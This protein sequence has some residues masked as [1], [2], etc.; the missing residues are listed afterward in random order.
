MRVV[1]ASWRR[2]QQER[3]PS[4][5]RQHNRCSHEL[6]SV[7]KPPSIDSFAYEISDDPFNKTEPF[8]YLLALSGRAAWRVSEKNENLQQVGQSILDE[9][10]RSNKQLKRLYQ[11]IIDRHS[12]LS[13]RRDR[14]R[15]RILKNHTYKQS[16]QAQDNSV[17]PMLYGPDE[18][19]SYLKQRLTPNYSITKRVLDEAKSLTTHED[20]APKNII[21]FG[22]GVGSA[23]A[24]AMDVWKD[25]VEWVHG[26]DSSKSMREASTTLLTRYSASFE[27]QSYFRVTTSG[28]LAAE[29]SPPAFDL[30]LFTYTALELTH[31]E[32]V[33]SAAALLW[34]KLRPNG[35]F[36]MIEPGTPDGF[37]SIRTVRN[38]LID[39]CSPEYNDGCEVLAPCSHKGSCPLE[40]FQIQLD[41][42][43]IKGPTQF[44]QGE[45]DD[46]DIEE[47]E[48][49]GSDDEDENDDDI[50]E[51]K[52]QKALDSIKSGRKR[53]KGRDKRIETLIVNSKAGDANTNVGGRDD[54]DDDG[55]GGV[56]GRELDDGLRKGYCSFVQAMPDNSKLRKGEKFSYI[57]LRKTAPDSQGIHKSHAFS[58]DDVTSLLEQSLNPDLS[59][60]GQQN[61]FGRAIDLH[62]RYYGSDEDDLGLELVRGSNLSSFGRIV[63]APIKKR[64][65]VYIDCCVDPGAITRHRITKSS[66]NTA[67]GLYHA[68]RKSRW[69]GLWPNT[70][71]TAEK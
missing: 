16:E 66:G 69:G 58:N 63:R 28:F 11:S 21:D 59:S 19:F 2:L 45:F 53:N 60:I 42:R 8:K 55:V 46:V 49:V 35:L 3:R 57:V 50:D 37:S 32:A 67:P 20:F 12:A 26:V 22:V 52:L 61:V 71:S 39:C 68:A 51:E 17:K 27:D 33:L 30:A 43:R 7:A 13:N 18:T 62:Q 41:R 29:A 40:R 70:S 15:L 47:E 44:E 36:V 31:N 14:E 38:M 25:S 10:G 6:T 1:R 64:G 24:A 48:E 5:I 9:S 65:H 4:A 54:D 23:S 56:N 34:D